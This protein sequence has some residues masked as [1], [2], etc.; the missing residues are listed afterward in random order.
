MQAVTSKSGT[1]HALK[2]YM[3]IS[4]C[5]LNKIVNFYFINLFKSKEAL[6]CIPY[7]FIVY[8]CFANSFF[9]YQLACYLS[10]IFYVFMQKIC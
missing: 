1:V 6:S 10:I 5:T 3:W 4:V 8:D 7:K 9:D 2:I